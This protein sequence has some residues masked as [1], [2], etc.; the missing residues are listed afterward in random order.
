MALA[1]LFAGDGLVAISDDAAVPLAEFRAALTGQPVKPPDGGV[2]Q[3]VDAWNSAFRRAVAAGWMESDERAIAK[4]GLSR[5]RAMTEMEQLWG[6]PLSAER[7]KRAGEDANAQR[8]GR[9][10]RELIAELQEA[11]ADGDDN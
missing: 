8:R 3:R 10:S 4:L 7:D 11:I 1:D 9:V 6:Q 5:S 2:S